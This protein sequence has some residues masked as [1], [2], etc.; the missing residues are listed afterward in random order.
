MAHITSKN[1][2]HTTKAIN[3]MIINGIAAIPSRKFFHKCSP[4][5]RTMLN[6]C[7]DASI[8]SAFV[9][10]LALHPWHDATA[11]RSLYCAVATEPS[12]TLSPS[13]PPPPFAF[14]SRSDAPCHTIPQSH[15]HTVF[16]PATPTCMPSPCQQPMLPLCNQPDSTTV[17]PC[18]VRQ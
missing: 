4:P 2:A 5:G 13:S 6:L 7:A 8:T 3:S 15:T 18:L 1:S 12:N 17:L 16:L 10:A 9:V 11:P 14:P